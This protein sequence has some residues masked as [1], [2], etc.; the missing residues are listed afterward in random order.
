MSFMVAAP[1]TLVPASADVGSIGSTVSAANAAA[2]SA[3]TTVAAAAGDEVSAAIASLISSHA[4]EYQA[5]SAQA[6]AY[7]PRGR[8][9]S[10]SRPGPA[11]HPLDGGPT[12][13]K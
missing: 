2:A 10:S 5:L 3:T 4:Q 1:E 7:S 13:F 6:A 12:A 8:P 9:D 11:R